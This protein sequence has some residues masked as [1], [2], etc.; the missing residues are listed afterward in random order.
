M[1]LFEKDY[2]GKN[3]YDLKRDI[4]EAFEVKFNPLIKD[5]PIDQHGFPMGKFTVTVTW[6]KE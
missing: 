2:D 4:A 3:L 1:T 6:S 5:V